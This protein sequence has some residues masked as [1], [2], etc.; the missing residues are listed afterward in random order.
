MKYLLISLLCCI[1]LPCQAGADNK[2]AVAQARFLI[3]NHMQQTDI[4]GAQLAVWQHGQLIW[5]EAFGQANLAS[6]QQMTPEMPMRI[7]SISKALTAVTMMQLV[8]EG[9]L[10]LDKTL[11]HY[12]PELPPHLHEITLRQLAA[13][14]AGVRHYNDTDMTNHTD[15]AT[16]RAAVNRFVNDPLEFSPGTQFGYSSYGWVLIAVVME[17]VTAEPFSRLMQRNWQQQKLHHTFLDHPRFHP[18]VLSAQYD[19]QQ[20]SWWRSWLLGQQPSRI[21]AKEEDRSFIY[22]GGGFLST[23]EDLVQVGTQLLQGQL[24]QP[25]SIEQMWQPYRLADG[26]LSHYAL[27]WETGTDRLG[28]RVVFHSGS[29][30]SARSHLIIYPEQQ[31]VAAIL[32]NTGQHVFFNEEEAQSLAELFLADA[33]APPSSQLT[34]TWQL[35]TT[36]LRDKETCGQ[37]SLHTD[38]KTGLVSGEVDF[39]RSDTRLQMPLLLTAATDEHFSLVAVSPMFIHFQLRLEQG[40][41]R[42]NWFHH[43]NVNGAEPDSYWRPREIVATRKTQSN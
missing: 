31:L 24:L 26:T 39:V 1:A 40:Q 36:S 27:G 17:R 16:A 25:F 6:G 5:S 4:P 7:A 12:L 14:T 19:L 29:M 21:A 38:S 42:G 22:S 32:F 3:T 2:L 13:S 34:G 8:E 20:P 15:Y 28:N 11:Q 30:P 43:I 9:K 18:A 10:Q 37:M 23:A 35:C 41:L 33:V